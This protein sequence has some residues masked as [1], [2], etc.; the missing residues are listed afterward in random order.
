MGGGEEEEEERGAES[1]LCRH[2][3]TSPLTCNKGVVCVDMIEPL[4]RLHV[5]VCIHL[6][7]CPCACVRVRYPSHV[8]V[9][10]CVS[11][12]LYVLM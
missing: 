3:N 5:C 9:C 2:S 4:W 12:R 10:A 6:C 8:C 11:A 7:I 1:L